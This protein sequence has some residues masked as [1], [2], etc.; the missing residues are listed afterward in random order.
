MYLLPKTRSC[1]VDIYWNRQDDGNAN[2]EGAV[3]CTAKMAPSRTNQCRNHSRDGQE[4][5]PKAMRLLVHPLA[6]L[7]LLES[8]SAGAGV[9]IQSATSLPVGKVTPVLPPAERHA[10]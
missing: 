10:A 6:L 2:Y 7:S 1:E 3:H 5:R 4:R 9:R 8:D